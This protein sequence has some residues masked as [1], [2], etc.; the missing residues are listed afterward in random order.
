MHDLT[1]YW[2]LLY[3][4]WNFMGILEWG[5]NIYIYMYIYNGI[6]MVY[7]TTSNNNHM[8]GSEKPHENCHFFGMYLPWEN[9]IDSQTI[10]T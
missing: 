6:Y 9:S 10:K 4:T 3:L 8:G 5:Y 1:T 7:I 2:S